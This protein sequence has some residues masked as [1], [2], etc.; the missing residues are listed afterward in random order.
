MYPTARLDIL[1]FPA[2]LAAPLDGLLRKQGARPVLLDGVRGLHVRRPGQAGTAV[3]EWL[4]AHGRF[5]YL[6]KVTEPAA[7]DHYLRYSVGAMLQ[8]WHPSRDG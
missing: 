3:Q 4:I 7:S 2:S 8:S 5:G 1:A 6:V